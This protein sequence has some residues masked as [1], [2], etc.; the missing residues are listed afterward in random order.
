M[1]RRVRASRVT[2]NYKEKN[3]RGG[4]DELEGD[5]LEVRAGSVNL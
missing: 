5:L 2:G 4:V 1:G 3:I